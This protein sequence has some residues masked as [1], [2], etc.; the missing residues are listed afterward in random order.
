MASRIASRIASCSGATA[1]LIELY[2]D[3]D[4]VHERLFT[5]QKQP[6]FMGIESIR[7]A[8]LRRSQLDNRQA[9]IVH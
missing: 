5:V 7:A 2:R 6:E 8:Q 4:C 3:S 1:L 9:T